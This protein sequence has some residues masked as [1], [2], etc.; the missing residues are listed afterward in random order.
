MVFAG[1]VAYQSF[2]HNKVVLLYSGLFMCHDALG[3]NH[4][5]V[6]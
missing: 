1:C 6:I 2:L 3:E 5:T 4:F